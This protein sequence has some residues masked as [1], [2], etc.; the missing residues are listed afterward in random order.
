MNFEFQPST[1][2]LNTAV[3][4][5]V[6]LERM[7]DGRFAFKVRGGRPLAVPAT[8]IGTSFELMYSDDVGGWA[9]AVRKEICRRNL[10]GVANAYLTNS[11][12]KVVAHGNKGRWRSQASVL[13][14][15]IQFYSIPTKMA[16]EQRNFIRAFVSAA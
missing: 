8:E 15:E 7:P 16:F 4:F 5:P 9:N 12:E 11:R 10:V 14:T 13:S 3:P 1:M 6:E 2:P